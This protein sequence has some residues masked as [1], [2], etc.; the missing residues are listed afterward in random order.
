MTSVFQI[1]D[2]FPDI[3]GS[4]IRQIYSCMGEI[5]QYNISVIKK[6]QKTKIWQ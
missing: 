1:R 2:Q 5:V 3:H 6:K 4:P